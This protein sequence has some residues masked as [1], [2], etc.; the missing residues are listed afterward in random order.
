[1]VNAAC[2]RFE[3]ALRAG[4]TDTP[5]HYLTEAPPFLRSLMLRELVAL[6]CEYRTGPLST[7]STNQVGPY[8]LLNELGRGGF[9]VVYR[10]TDP[11]DGGTYAV[12]VPHPAA[13]AEPVFQARFRREAEAATRLQHPGIVRIHE[14]QTQ[15]SDCYIAAEYVAGLNLAEW[16]AEQ[17]GAG[18]TLTVPQAAGLVL[19]LA[20]AVQHAHECGVLHRDLKPSNILLSGVRVPG[21]STG[22][23]SDL[24]SPKITDF[25]LAR[26][27]DGEDDLSRTGQILGT[28]AYMAPEQLV[29]PRGAVSVR[30]DVYALGNILYELL[31]G[32]PPFGGTPG[33]EM[34]VRLLHEE[35]PEMRRT[36]RDLP[37]ELVAICLT[38]LEKNPE[39]RY[40]SAQNLADDLRRFLTGNRTLARPPGL[41][42][43]GGRWIHRRPLTSTAIAATLFLLAGAA[44]HTYRLEAV[45][46]D[47]TA[48]LIERDTSNRQYRRAAYADS[49]R[50]IEAILDRGDLPEAQRLLAEWE[51]GPGEELRGWEWYYLSRRT[52]RGQLACWKVGLTYTL[53]FRPDGAMLAGGGADRMLRLWNPDTGQELMPPR[54]HPADIG[55]LLW[56]S[57]G[58]WLASASDDGIIRIWMM[59]GGAAIQL[60]GHTDKLKDLALSADGRTLASVGKDGTVRL[61]DT[62]DWTKPGRVLLQ[63][64]ANLRSVAFGPNGTILVSGSYD[65]N[66]KIWDQTTGQLR[67]SLKA[68]TK[69]I[70]Y[71]RGASGRTGFV[72]AARD[73]RLWEP[74]AS[75][76]SGWKNVALPRLI[77]R[78][79]DLALS[80][81]SQVLAV[82]GDTGATVWSWE[83]ARFQS[84][85]YGHHGIVHAVSLHPD[86]RRM[87]TSGEDGTVRIWDLRAVPVASQDTLT[88]DPMLLAALPD[89]LVCVT[90]QSPGWQVLT[91]HRSGQSTIARHDESIAGVEIAPDGNALLT[92]DQWGQASRWSSDASGIGS[93]F[94]SFT[95][96]ITPYVRGLATSPDGQ[97]IVSA[98]GHQIALVE[99]STGR[100]VAI[101]SGK[102][103]PAA[104]VFSPD[105]RLLATGGNESRVYLWEAATGEQ[106]AALPAQTG[107]VRA[108]AFSPDSKTIAYAG[109][110]HA[111]HFWDLDGREKGLL[112]GHRGAVMG[113]AFSP[114]G[115]TLA[116]VSDDGTC[117]LWQLS[118]GSEMLS[119]VVANRSITHV[120]FNPDGRYL[121][122]AGPPDATHPEGFLETHDCGG[123]LAP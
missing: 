102:E 123:P 103:T 18:K 24:Q 83:G 20:E 98:I 11:R 2:E 50:H 115:R 107:M 116:S 52:R 104:M 88:G 117:R 55:P 120:A 53:A 42:R 61:W 79:R 121:A 91:R 69:P 93:P 34:L 15:G 41:I 59:S 8:T 36:R 54:P 45:N 74:S 76:P 87:A 13:L 60:K 43:R 47:L 5:D 1:M 32:Q 122:F 75:E 19:A 10:A 56:A 22:D 40:A 63:E 77:D 46:A 73:V 44:I 89:R 23:D 26:L 99:A 21:A 39:R 9:G 17:K 49:I 25:G 109:D 80:S 3:A 14:V 33:M 86:R 100:Q 12:K 65:N 35:P 51:K 101:L 82:A 68:H 96:V 31:I 113:L 112:S 67:G 28:P 62:S 64:S 30:T 94:F 7:K 6:E 85:V 58:K 48:A 37:A 57:D 71:V 92:I 111:I 38:C 84:R 90:T 78:M 106:R 72:T 119:F 70:T 108:V 66:I 95:E 97:R 29:G 110:D 118:T 114:D 105:S 81:D 4:L 16:L 27:G